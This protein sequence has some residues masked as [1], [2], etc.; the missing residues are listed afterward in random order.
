MSIADIKIG[1]PDLLRVIHKELQD[2]PPLPSIVVQAMETVNNPSASAADL[3]RLIAMDPALS[4]KVLRVVNSAHYG[5]SSQITTISHAIVILGFD[6]VRNLV[7]ALG[8]GRALRPSARHLLNRQR[9]WEHSVATAVGTAVIGKRRRLDTA[10]CEEVFVGGLL[11]DMG[12]LFLDQFFPDQYRV[13]IQL[14]IVG[15][16]GMYRAEAT[17]LGIDHTQVGKRIADNWRLPPAANAMI[18]FHHKPQLSGRY[19][20][21]VACVHAA[22]VVAKQLKLG[23]SGDTV[24]PTMDAEVAKWLAFSPADWESVNQTVTVEFEKAREL[25]SVMGA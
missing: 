19:F 8:V 24:A 17:A 13:A 25:V 20:E 4:A 12:K 3:N 1:Q 2:L 16:V 6:S 18:T 21:Y 22:N 7:T 9:F 11:H 15:K 10:I 14:A 23:S 5:F